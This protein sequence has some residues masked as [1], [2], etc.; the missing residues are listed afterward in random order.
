MVNDKVLIF[1]HIPKCGGNTFH[2]ILKRQ[3]GDRNTFSIRVMGDGK[4][5]TEE[6]KR[7]SKEEK[8][9]LNLVKGHMDY[10]LHSHFNRTVE[11]ITF[12]RNPIDRVISEYR[13]IKSKKHHSLH[14][15]AMKHSLLSYVKNYD[16]SHNIQI[17]Y[18]SGIRGNEESMLNTAIENLNTHFPVVG[19]LE[20][21][22]ES[23][24][25]MRQYFKW[26]IP[27]YKRQ[28]VTNSK[29][30]NEV[31]LDEREIIAKYNKGDIKLYNMCKERFEQSIA[32]KNISFS[33]EKY[34]LMGLS[35]IYS[36]TK[37]VF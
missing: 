36:I 5:N 6:F 22:D 23:L 17:K 12:L 33:M 20:Y 32:E 28:N 31:S 30:K 2:Q 16:I 13:Y 1:L 34:S 7:L 29:G 27:F 9:K 25:M 3:Y 35:K 37:E 10:G 14:D 15:Y 4:V 18:I 8:S 21:Y 24:V 19:L 11:Y 26:Q